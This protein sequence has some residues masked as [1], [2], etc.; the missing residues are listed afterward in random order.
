MKRSPRFKCWMVITGIIVLITLFATASPASQVAYSEPQPDELV[1]RAW[2]RAQRVGVYRF[3]TE[4]VQTTYPAPRLSNV[5]RS[6]SSETA[7][8]EG[9]ANLPEHKLLMTLWKGGSVANVSNGVEVRIEGEHAYGRQTGGAWQEMDNFS[10]AFAPGSDLMAYLAGAKNIRMKAEG[11]K[12][13]SSFTFDVDGP[14]FAE[15]LR[16]Q[17][18]R[19]L[20]EKGELPLGLSL[21]SSNTYREVQ[22]QG[23]LWIDER[24]L[25]LRLTVHLAYPEQQSGERVEADIR[26]DFSGFPAVIQPPTPLEQIL[27]LVPSTPRDWQQAVAQA[28]VLLTS[29]GL[30]FVLVTNARSRKI[31]AAFVLASLSQ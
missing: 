31:Y 26:T 6:S 20:I 16:S 19:Y 7:H 18:E 24:G 25:P 11:G 23:E 1:Q 3:T 12:M 13:N 27:G 8:L 9:Q 14:A 17:L 2:Q 29:A 10:D 15:Y 22:G 5:G 28:A 30:L 4:I 21:D